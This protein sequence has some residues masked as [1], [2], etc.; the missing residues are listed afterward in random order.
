MFCNFSPG[1]LKKFHFR[2]SR[3]TQQESFSYS[4]QG[5]INQKLRVANLDSLGLGACIR[6]D[7]NIYHHALI[8]RKSMHDDSGA[9]L[10]PASYVLARNMHS[11]A[12]SGEIDIVH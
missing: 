11:F 5:Q 3:A 12:S 1:R 10:L 7:V 2:F 4:V 9:L 6:V 8:S